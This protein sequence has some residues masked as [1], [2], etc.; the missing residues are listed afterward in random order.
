M[1]LAHLGAHPSRDTT[2]VSKVLPNGIMQPD[3]LTDAPQVWELYD[4]NAGMGRMEDGPKQAIR[5]A[6]LML[7]AQHP[8]VVIV[9]CACTKP[10]NRGVGEA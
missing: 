6:A 5:E 9:L 8:H 1:Y 7:R 4:E 10:L 3:G 2:I